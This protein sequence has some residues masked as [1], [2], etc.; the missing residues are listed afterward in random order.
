MGGQVLHARCGCGFEREILS[1]MQADGAY[2]LPA[3][4]EECRTFL[5]AD[6]RNARC[7]TC[8]KRPIFFGETAHKFS[9]FVLYDEKKHV[10]AKKRGYRVKP[11]LEETLAAPMSGDLYWCAS[12]GQKRL[13]FSYDAFWE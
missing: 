5:V 7:P 6:Y 1:G 11:Y 4:C 8:G 3:V 12:C 13:R 2:H 10:P 9:N